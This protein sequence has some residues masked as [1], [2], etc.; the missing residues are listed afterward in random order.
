MIQHTTTPAPRQRWLTLGIV[1]LGVSVGAF[2]NA[3]NIALPAITAAFGIPLTAIQWVVIC[4]VLTYGSLLLGCGRLSDIVGHKRVFLLGV[5]CS[6]VAL[7]LCGW[8]PSFGWLL[9][10]RGLQGLGAALVFSTGP[11]LA[12]LA[13]AETER[14]K[15]LGVY[16]M[17]SAIAAALGPLLG[18]QGLALWGWSAVFHFRVPIAVLSGLLTVWCLR[19]PVAVA[20]GQRFD[21][22]GAVT[23]TAALAGVLLALNQSQHLAWASISMLGLSAGACLCLGWFVYHETHCA[24]PVINLRLFRYGAFT[25]ANST[26]VLAYFASFAVLLLVPYYLLTYYRASALLGGLLLAM[27]PLGTMLASPLGGRLLA[28]LPAQRVSVYGLGCMVLG[29]S[30]VSQWQ[31]QSSVLVIAGTLLLQGFGM[32]LFHVA[33]M[34]FVMGAIPR[35]QQGVAGSLTML[36]RTIGIV[37]GATVWA[38]IMGSW[39]PRYTAQ[40]LGAGVP[41]AEAVPQAFLFAFQGA[42]WSAA[43]VAALAC[44]LMWHR[45]PARDKTG[46][47]P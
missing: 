39:Q 16:T 24:E 17:L 29:L 45:W 30:G 42:F 3:V 23:L 11:A 32:G 4:Y 13:F 10:F 41:H 26:Q 14:S 31:L 40:L 9:C 28:R 38:W 43:A 21:S 46:A 36:T 20:P 35:H 18:G 5:W 44:V 7:L 8:A 15:V 12:T 25:M 6:A 27:S 47:V 1:G 34:D 33:N 22:L 2:D 19:Q 37:I